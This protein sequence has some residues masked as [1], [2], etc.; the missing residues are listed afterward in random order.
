MLQALSTIMSNNNQQPPTQ[1]PTQASQNP[2][3]PGGNGTQTFENEFYNSGRIGRRNALPDILK[4]EHACT[5][6]GD[7]PLKLSAL[8]TNG[9]FFYPKLS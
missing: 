1:Q 8:T 6:T 2:Q 4:N 5:A 7:L 9:E 3:H